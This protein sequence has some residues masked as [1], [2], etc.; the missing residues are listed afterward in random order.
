M[1]VLNHPRGL[2]NR[3]SLSR[4]RRRTCKTAWSS[5]LLATP[6]R[7][8]T[9]CELASIDGLLDDGDRAPA[10]GRRQPALR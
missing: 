6:N 7:S 9:L 4:R 8:G 5:V 10:I 2:P 1:A 3:P